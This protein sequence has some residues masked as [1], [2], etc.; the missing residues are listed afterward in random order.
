MDGVDFI[1]RLDD[2]SLHLIFDQ[3][4]TPTQFAPF[5]QGERSTIF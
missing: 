5:G 3:F 4:Q 2:D 1:N